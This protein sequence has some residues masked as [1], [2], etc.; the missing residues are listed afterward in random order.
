MT[1]TLAASLVP[2]SQCDQAEDSIDFGP[3]VQLLGDS[4]WARG[5]IVWL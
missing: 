5:C 4:L 2:D 3:W 1:Y